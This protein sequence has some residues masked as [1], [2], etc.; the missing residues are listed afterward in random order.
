MDAKHRMRRAHCTITREDDGRWKVTL[1]ERDTFLRSF[2]LRSWSRAVQ[3]AD[4]VARRRQEMHA[5]RMEHAIR[6]QTLADEI[7]TLT[8][9][10]IA[11]D[12]R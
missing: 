8:S 4:A 3:A 1:W 7:D 9:R 5:L 12:R 11:A 2:Y 6:I 10:A